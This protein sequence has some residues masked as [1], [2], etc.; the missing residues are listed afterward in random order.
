MNPHDL[1]YHCS[2]HGINCLFGKF[3]IKD[4]NDEPHFPERTESISILIQMN[5]LFKTN[6]ER[7]RMR[8]EKVYTRL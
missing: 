3:R 6:G 4:S 1:C 5:S 2:K 8:C 7:K